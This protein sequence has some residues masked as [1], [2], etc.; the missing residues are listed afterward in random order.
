VAH[1]D[2]V[3]AFQRNAALKVGRHFTYV[4]LEALEAPTTHIR[5]HLT[6]ADYPH[7]VVTVDSAI[8]HEAAG[9]VAL[10]ADAEDL[11]YLGVAV[12]D[13][14]VNRF[15]HALAGRLKVLDQVVDDAVLLDLDIL[16]LSQSLGAG[17]G[18]RVE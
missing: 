11:T 17:I 7:E 18:C 16:G 3:G 8:R 9:N 15:E 4:I 14:C 2:V 13:I 1:L 12:N 6:V 10:A 5:D